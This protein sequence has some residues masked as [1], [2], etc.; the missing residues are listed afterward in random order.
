MTS[1]E[2]IGTVT[3]CAHSHGRA[4]RA[5]DVLETVEAACRKAGLRLTPIR[6]SVLETLLA[7]HMPLGAYDIVELMGRTSSKRLAP[8]TIYRALEFLQDNGFVHR[9]ETRNAFMACSH[10]H[11]ATDLVVFMICEDCGG[12]DEADGGSVTKVLDQLVA[13]AG[14]VPHKRVVEMSGVC[15]HCRK[16]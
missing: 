15:E 7:T 6:R 16:S 12:I 14:F 3:G 8:I 13:G 1:S 11:S 2:H 4:A 9:L 10:G 5:G